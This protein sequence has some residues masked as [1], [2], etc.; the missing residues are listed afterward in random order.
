MFDGTARVTVNDAPS[1][2]LTTAMTLEAWVSP[3]IAEDRWRDVIY[4]GNDNYYLMAS[5]PN[6]PPGDRWH[7]SRVL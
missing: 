5:T 3:T 6:G 4:K 1:L 7:D 2:D